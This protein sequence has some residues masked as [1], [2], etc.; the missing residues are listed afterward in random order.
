METLLLAAG[1]VGRGDEAAPH[2]V[3]ELLGNK[4]NVVMHNVSR[5]S[6]GLAEEIARADRVMFIDQAR[7]LGDPWMEP[8]GGE[9]APAALVALAR[10][11]YRFSG[12]AYVCYVP[13][14][15]FSE[16]TDLSP[17]GEVRARQA[18]EL[19]QRFLAA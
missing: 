9:S 5:W 16:G 8:T 6:D 18:A 17:Y 3:L 2:R 4:P 1:E 10:N 7:E 11:L 15:D 14:L 19:I 12:R 13:G